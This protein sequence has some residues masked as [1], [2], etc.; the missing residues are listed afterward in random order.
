MWGWGVF[1]TR[2]PHILGHLY[3]RDRDKL[4]ACRTKYNTHR[5]LV[6][7]ACKLTINFVGSLSFSATVMQFY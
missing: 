3:I 7:C 1:H 6:C 5:R 2:H 4:A